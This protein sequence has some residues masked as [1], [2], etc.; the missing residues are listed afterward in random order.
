MNP[1]AGRGIVPICVS[2][3]PPIRRFR[4]TMSPASSILL[5][6]GETGTMKLHFVTPI[7]F[8]VALCL[9]TAVQAQGVPG[10]VAHG[11]AVGNQ[12][13]GP[14]GAVVGSVVGGVIGGVEGVFG[15]DPRP[16]YSGY[17]EGRPYRVYRHRRV[18]RH[19]RHLRHVS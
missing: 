4:R 15:V 5:M 8:V 13:A 3:T 6:H 12:A 10:G 16:A 7:G 9:T 18:A 2:L 1:N 14:V 19:S 11:A 17:P